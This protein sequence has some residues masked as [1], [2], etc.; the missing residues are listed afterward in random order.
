VLIAMLRK[1]LASTRRAGA[2]RKLTRAARI[3]YPLY[4]LGVVATYVVLFG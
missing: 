2:E 1:R 3:G 4:L